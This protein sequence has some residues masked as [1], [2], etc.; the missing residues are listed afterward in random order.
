MSQQKKITR[1][2]Y[3]I[4]ADF[5]DLTEAMESA[6]EKE[7]DYAE[8][9][10]CV[11]IYE[12]IMGA[13]EDIQDLIEDEFVGELVDELDDEC[14]L[15]GK[16]TIQEIISY[17]CDNYQIERNIIRNRR[18]LLSEDMAQ[19]QVEEISYDLNPEMNTYEAATYE[20]IV[21]WITGQQLSAEEF[22][23]FYIPILESF[24][25]SSWAFSAELKR[26]QAEGLQISAEVSDKAA[27]WLREED[28]ILDDME[29]VLAEPY[30][31]SNRIV[32]TVDYIDQETGDQKV[33]VFTNYAET[34][35]KYEY[36]L[37]L[38]FGEEK[39]A[40]FNKKMSAD[41]LEMNIYRFQNVKECRILLCD[42][43]GGEG[44]NLQIADVV[45]HIDL[46]WDANAIEQRIGRLDR[47]GRD[48]GKPVLSI[49]VLTGG[50]L[51][52][53]L[54]R[55]WKDGLHVF[56]KSLSGLEI[57]MNEIND[58]IINAVT[59]DFRYGIS[60]AIESVVQASQKMEQDIRQEQ[61]FDTASFIYGALNQQL[62]VTLDKYHRNENQMFADSM[63]GWATLAG[64]KGTPTKR[65]IVSFSERSFSVGSAVKS[66]FI[67]P[68]W[69]EYINKRSTTFARKYQDMYEENQGN[70]RNNNERLLQGTFDRT[71][72]IENDYLHFFA[73]G[74]EVYD[75][76]V[77]NALR[78]DKGQCA[79]FAFVGE[80][81]W[82]GFV[83]TMTLEPNVELLL[84][85][86]IPVTAIGKYKSYISMD[87]IIVPVGL[88]AYA[89]VPAEKIIAQLEKL[90][91]QP[92]SKQ[93]G[94]AAH[95]GRRKAER[96][97]LG[98]KD[99]YRC[100]N[101]DWFKAKFPEE[102][103]QEN[104]KYA[105][106]RAS[107]IA[108]DRFRKSSS[109]KSAKREVDRMM[110]ASISKSRYYG[111]EPE[112]LEKIKEQYMLIIEALQKSRIVIEAAAF[113]LVVKGNDR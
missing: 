94:L 47:L 55:F 42:E 5:E 99:Q 84:E 20:A 36:V 102:I 18:G 53:E 106:K 21:D 73:P 86:D 93:R 27:E 17:V 29:N 39:V 54:F 108:I 32:S 44:R 92:V 1:S 4:L 34:F 103:W 97:F 87:Q 13:I 71:M 10:D 111:T 64:F 105:R 63:M 15:K 65:G 98:I 11:D 56:D 58:S 101:L 113:V 19:R 100:S 70:R 89:D 81:N 7:I 37:R 69:E 110:N 2:M 22:S 66:L 46:P 30:N 3:N 78:S 31:Y 41:D 95:L 23:K 72:A 80:I 76:I 109:L 74:D 85:N 96:D 43:S 88:E 28:E 68:R 49:V 24:F 62:K 33:V 83:F 50:T 26:Q 77:N 79:A 51:E 9:G 16:S 40:T 8:D 48:P 52:Q 75:S 61:L 25:S 57:I 6:E 45:L 12:D 38:Y 59:K 112:Q 107:D 60:D 82:Q 91:S 67:P 104:V 35:T 14:S 90:Y